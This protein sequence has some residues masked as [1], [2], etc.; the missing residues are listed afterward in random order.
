VDEDERSAPAY[1]IPSKKHGS[2]TLTHHLEQVE[3]QSF[4]LP[5]AQLASPAKQDLLL[6][7]PRYRTLKELRLTV[8]PGNKHAC[9]GTQQCCPSDQHGYTCV[10]KEAICC[11]PGFNTYC[12][13][14]TK[15]SMDGAICIP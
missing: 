12:P 9:P 13:A 7:I 8:C 15:C 1:L 11:S 6:Q 3:P 14:G 10:P 2:P 5:L 4:H